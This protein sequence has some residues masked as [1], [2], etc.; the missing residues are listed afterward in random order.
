MTKHVRST[1]PLI[2]GH[3]D[4]PYLIRIELKNHIY[5]NRFPFEEGLLSPTDLVKLRTGRF[6]GQ[7]WSAYIPCVDDI[8]EE[9]DTPT[10]YIFQPSTFHYR[11]FDQYHCNMVN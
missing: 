6:G 8:G 2:D 4:M 9:F 5:D 3:N 11:N 10:Q 1:T 7:F